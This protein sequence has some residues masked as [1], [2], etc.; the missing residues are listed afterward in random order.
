[1]EVRPQKTY[2]YLISVESDRHVPDD[3]LLFSKVDMYY[4]NKNG[5]PEDA[6]LELLTMQG[7][8]DDI[9]KIPEDAEKGSNTYLKGIYSGGTTMDCCQTPVDFMS[10]DIDCDKKVEGKKVKINQWLHNT[11]KRDAVLSILE[12]YSVFTGVSSSGKGLFG[13]IHVKRLSQFDHTDKERHKDCC[14]AICD[15]LSK[16]ILEETGIEV[17]FDPAQS[18]YRQ[19]RHGAYQ[20]TPLKVNKGYCSLSFEEQVTETV[21]P[22]SNDVALR[23]SNGGYVGSAYQKF[24]KRHTVEEF[25]PALGFTYVRDNRYKWYG[26]KSQTTGQVVDGVF[27]SNSSTFSNGHGCECLMGY[28]AY[29]AAHLYMISKGFNSFG[30]LISDLRSKGITHDVMK[31]SDF[32]D[33]V[34]KADTNPKVAELCHRFRFQDYSTRLKFFEDAPIPENMREHFRHYLRIKDLKIPHDEEYNIE[35]VSD[36]A[37]M[38]FDIVDRKKK[39]ALTAPTGSGKTK[40][41]LNNVHKYRPLYRVLFIV[42]YIAIAAQ[43]A[44][45]SFPVPHTAVYG[46]NPKAHIWKEAR[47]LPLVVATYNHATTLLHHPQVNKPD[48]KFDLI[49]IDELHSL[50]LGNGFRA[51]PLKELDYAILKYR[52]DNEDIKILGLTGTPLRVFKN[53]GYHRVKFHKPQPPIELTLRFDGR[54]IDK[55]IQNH[56]LGVEKDARVFYIAKAVQMMRD[57]REN[58]ILSGICTEAQSIVFTGEHEKH[59]E[60]FLKLVDDEL[61]RSEITRVYS[62]PLLNEGVSIMNEEPFELVYNDDSVNWRV[63]NVRQFLS[64]F[65]NESGK[66]KKYLYVPKRNEDV[67]VDY[68]DG[69]ESEAVKIKGLIEDSSSGF[70]TYGGLASINKYKHSDKSMYEGY[71]AFEESERE[72]W[73]LTT[74][75][76]IESLR[77]NFNVKVTIDEEYERTKFDSLKKK[78]KGSREIKTEFFNEHLDAIL[79]QFFLTAKGRKEKERIECIMPLP[80]DVSEEV[81]AFVK[82]Y[83]KDIYNI[84]HGYSWIRDY[85]EEHREMLFNKDGRIETPERLKQKALF[86]WLQHNLQL[87][88]SLSGIQEDDKKQK[89]K[90]RNFIGRCKESMTLRDCMKIWEDCKLLEVSTNRGKAALKAFVSANTPLVWADNKSRFI[91]KEGN[92]YAVTNFMEDWMKPFEDLYLEDM[93]RKPPDSRQ[94]EIAF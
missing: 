50:I 86:V 76:K 66:A 48:N 65:R 84:L 14:N 45:K 1:M 18:R 9:N 30:E 31:P 5:S 89:A 19:L 61:L 68:V 17:E 35:W 94:L 24:N 49:V 42:P 75:E 36:E 28:K 58:A 55:I 8:I 72:N 64:R 27:I 37:E 88:T 51:K 56:E 70:S 3:S 60:D 44:N 13:V 85:S 69:Y 73:A 80:A 62:S 47:T 46:N 81:V 83:K 34:R 2:S 22:K 87:D 82:T 12:E 25:L 57:S 74:D 21:I 53:L 41:V 78:P 79:W 54:K 23:V 20:E 10:F 7:L 40:G 15:F 6:V 52:K 16:K 67:L 90:L 33:R 77:I 92:S 71:I 39:V 29:S 59:E 43:Q 93:E 11:A 91:K 26:S 63:E 38:L 4:D 32:Y